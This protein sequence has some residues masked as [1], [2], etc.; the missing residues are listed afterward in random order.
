MGDDITDIDFYTGVAS[1]QQRSALTRLEPEYIMTSFASANHNPL[2][3]DHTWFLDCGGFHHMAAGTGE[4]ETSNADYLSYINEYEPDLW[5]L[6][7]YPCEPELL[8]ALGRSVA[9]NQ[10]R[11]TER[12]ETLLSVAETHGLPG[13]PVSVIQGWTLTQYL[14]H[15]DVLRDRGLLTDYVGIGSIC[16]R[17]YDKEIAEIIL[18]I[19]DELPSR[20]RLHAFGVKGSVLRFA[21]VVDAL[22]SADSAAYD[23]A[24]SRTYGSKNESFTWRDSARAWLNWRYRL[25]NTIGSESLEIDGVQTTLTTHD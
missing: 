3:A 13:E 12:H 11:T 7:D 2:P 18:T 10:R 24:E 23:Y 17:G 1:G 20:C 19:R 5:A 14:S 25:S 22:D 4:Y 8:A 21:E 6:R 9:D 15:L 16:R